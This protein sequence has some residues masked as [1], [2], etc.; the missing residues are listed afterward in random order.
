M[1]GVSTHVARVLTDIPEVG[2]LAVW[3]YVWSAVVVVRG[4]VA[5]EDSSES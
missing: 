1:P 5:G 2:G 3:R 4:H